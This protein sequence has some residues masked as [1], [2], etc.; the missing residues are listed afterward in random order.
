[1]SISSQERQ[2]FAHCRK[3]PTAAHVS[4]GAEHAPELNS[5]VETVFF[6]SRSCRFS[7]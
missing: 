4:L 2:A 6:R 1:M 7:E 3:F 5:E